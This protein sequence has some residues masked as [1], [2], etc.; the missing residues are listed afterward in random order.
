MRG[1][2]PA[3]LI[4]IVALAGCTEEAAEAASS[5]A[6]VLA[7]RGVASLD[8]TLEPGAERYLCARRTLTEAVALRTV[9]LAAPP[10]TARVL[11]S[12]AEDEE[13]DGRYPCSATEVGERLLWASGPSPSAF[14]LP[15]GRALIVDAGE[16]VLLT[17][18]LINTGAE[19]LEGTTSF[20]GARTRGAV[21]P[22]Q[23]LLV[24]TRS[25]EVPAGQDSQVV[26]HCTLPAD[27]E[28]L[29]VA[30][31]GRHTEGGPDLSAVSPAGARRPIGALPE[32]YLA[33]DEPIALRRGDR[34]EAHCRYHNGS[35]RDLVYGE[36][37]T[38]AQ[39]YSA[40]L[41][42]PPVPSFATCLD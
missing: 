42:S 16:Q 18:H 31:L 41:I 22:A 32:S 11:V 13:P 24:G 25:V 26:G 17:L 19:R 14:S 9:A 39:C 36:H 35:D 1:L 12:V 7:H 34:L 27:T 38:D 23:V 8:W 6:Q 28:V 30:A 15:E 10:G 29:A 33:L 20:D 3:A 37:A 21:E 40:V 5:P 4:S 2:V